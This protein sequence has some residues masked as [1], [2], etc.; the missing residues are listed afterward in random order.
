MDTSSRFGLLFSFSASVIIVTV[1]LFCTR[2]F[3]LINPRWPSF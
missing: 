2:P 3:F 1:Q